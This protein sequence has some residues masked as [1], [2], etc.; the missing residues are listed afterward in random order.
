MT[1]P[2]WPRRVPAFS[3]P[4]FTYNVLVPIVTNVTPAP[5]ATVPVG[6]AITINGYNFVTGV[7]V[8]F[9][10]VTNTAPYY[11]P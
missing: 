2:A 10:P 6:G 8:G 5:P 3:A 1:S 4:V 11:R 9:C 7:T